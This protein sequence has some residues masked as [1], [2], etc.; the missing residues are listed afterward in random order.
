MDQENS[1]DMPSGRAALIEAALFCIAKYGQHG[2]TVRIIA[3]QAGVTAGLVKHHFG[4]KEALLVETY[5]HLNEGTV[6][7]IA[8]AIDSNPNDIG[9]AIETAIH[10]LFP[11]ELSDVSK[12]RVLVAF[13]GLVLT[14]ESFAAV[15]SETNAQTRKLLTNLIVKFQSNPHDAADIAD[16]IIAITDGLWLECCMNPAR[17]TPQKA[18]QTTLKLAVSVLGIGDKLH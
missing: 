9:R 1:Q 10:A 4:S 11:E 18:I 16:G 12:M 3:E 7:R 15:Q 6:S 13:W 17:M 8:Q 14:H 5:R 2:A